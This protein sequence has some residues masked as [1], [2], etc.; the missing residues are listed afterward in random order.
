MLIFFIELDVLCFVFVPV[1]FFCVQCSSVLTSFFVFL[2]A[3]TDMQALTYMNAFVDT[4][5]Y[6]YDQ[7]IYTV[8]L[9]FTDGY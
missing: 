8:M 4:S 5:M 9:L 2:H 6:C 7:Y 1:G 3:H